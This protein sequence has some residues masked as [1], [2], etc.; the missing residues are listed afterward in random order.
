MLRE[1]NISLIF[2]LFLCHT[3]IYGLRAQTFKHPGLLNTTE[4][5]SLIK[6]KVNEKE[7]P[8]K[9]GYLKIPVF[10]DHQPGPVDVYIDGAGHRDEQDINMQKL[11]ADGMAAYGSALHWVVTGDTAH[12]VK[13]IEIVNAWAY[14]LKQIDPWQDGSLSTSYGWPCLIYAA[15]IARHLY[16]GW[17]TGDVEGFEAFLSGLIWDGTEKAL[18]RENNWRS[19]AIF[20]RMAIAIFTDNRNRY[21]S[22]IEEL[23]KQILSY[24]YPSGQC[25]ETARDLWHSQMGMAPLVAACEMAW[26]QGDDLYSLENNRLLGSVEWHIPFIMD[27][28]EGWPKVFDSPKY[29]PSSPGNEGRP[30]P[31][32]EMMYN[33]YHNRLGF[34]TP[35]T[36]KIL[37]GTVAG[38]DEFP[39]RPEEW[40]RTGGW[41]TVTHAGDSTSSAVLQYPEQPLS[42]D[43]SQNYPNPFNS[44]TAIEYTVPA[45]CQVSLVIYSILGQEIIRLVE[46]R[47]LAGVYRTVWNGTDGCGNKV[48][49]GL[50]IVQMNAGGDVMMRK[51]VLME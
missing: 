2:C 38:F 23:K 51:M 11:T 7:E 17:K 25:L 3:G 14:T 16:S 5:Y 22:T 32:Y 8:W 46:T 36:W 30:W 45:D 10:L 6:K 39:V 31:F 18:K 26:H 35:N 9:S 27:E 41:G 12:I 47:N 20:C 29:E 4:D 49:S 28:T 40:E 50:Y 37:T 34:E 44:E 15:E 21:E 13:T 33:H 43:L 42:F 24:C 48:E 19:M 1:I